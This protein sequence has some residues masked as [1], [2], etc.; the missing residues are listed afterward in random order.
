MFAIG[1]QIYLTIISKCED[2]R[3]YA[4]HLHL[5]HALIAQFP[6]LAHY[7]ICLI[8]SPGS[9]YTSSLAMLSSFATNANK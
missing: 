3:S 2:H 6:H 1:Y 5:H 9:P 4:S 7:A 8:K